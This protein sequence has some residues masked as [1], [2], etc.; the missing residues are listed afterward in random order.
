MKAD[1]LRTVILK[2]QD[3]PKD[4]ELTTKSAAAMPVTGH[5]SKIGF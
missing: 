2:L 1:R 3:I 5:V 4:L